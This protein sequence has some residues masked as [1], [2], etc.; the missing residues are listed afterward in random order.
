VLAKVKRVTFRGSIINIDKD[1]ERS[2]EIRLT[3]ESLVSRKGLKVVCPA[4]PERI[5][6]QG[7]EIDLAGCRL[8]A[9]SKKAVA[10]ERGVN[11]FC[12]L[13]AP[14]R[15]SRSERWKETFPSGNEALERELDSN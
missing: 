1:R 4:I 8:T 9:A 10:T 3:S 5:I 12:S 2:R 13:G 6:F 15:P 7:G 11:F 14:P